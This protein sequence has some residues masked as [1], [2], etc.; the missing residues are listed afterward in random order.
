MDP[1]YPQKEVRRA[2]TWCTV[3]AVSTVTTP[4]SCCSGVTVE[5]TRWLRSGVVVPHVTVRP[6]RQRRH[7]RQRARRERRSRTRHV[8]VPR[9]CR[10]CAR[11]PV[12]LHGRLL[13]LG[14]CARMV[15][16]VPRGSRYH[17]RRPWTARRG[18]ALLVTRVIPPPPLPSR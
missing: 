7:L 15:G 10:L 16:D 9:F 2:P 12:G 1:R 3:T 13:S 4:T 5:E 11:R 18:R 6:L 8:V 17:L 14:S